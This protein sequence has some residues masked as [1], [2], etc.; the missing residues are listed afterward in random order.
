MYFENKYE[1]KNSTN[2]FSFKYYDADR[3][4]MGKIMKEHLSL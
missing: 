3:V 4:I 2:S 1:G